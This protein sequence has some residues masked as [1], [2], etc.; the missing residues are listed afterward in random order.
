MSEKIIKKIVDLE[1]EVQLKK[2]LKQIENRCV[3]EELDLIMK[4][5]NCNQEQAYKL[6][7]SYKDIWEFSSNVSTSGDSLI[8]TLPKKEAK[9]RGIEK[10]KPVLVALKKLRF[11]G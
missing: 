10:G 8:V 5:A 1:D 9:S 4:I 2:K 6:L 3:K 7:M 11:Y